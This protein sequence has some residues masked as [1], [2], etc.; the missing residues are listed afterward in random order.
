MG[1]LVSV[2][3]RYMPCL[4][5]AALALGMGQRV[6]PDAAWV[7]AND[8][9]L[10]YVGRVGFE[11][12][13]VAS[14]YYSASGFKARFRGRSLAL[15]FEEDDYGPA[16]S[17]GV[18]IDGAPEI[19]IRLVPKLDQ[20]YVVA[21]GLEDRVHDLEVFRRQDTYG[22]VAKFRGMLLD[23]GAKLENPPARS[24]RKIEF[25]GDS[26][27]G[28]T[29]TIAFGYE[30]KQDGAIA[31]ENSDAFL[32]DG[33]WSFGAI[34]ARRLHAE[35]NIEGIGGL[36]LLDH[37]GWFGGSLDRTIGL[38]TTWDK[39]DPIGGQFS[40]WNFSLFTPD[41]VVISI[42]QNDARGGNIQDAAWR[43]EWKDAYLHVLEGLRGHYPKAAIVLTTTILMHDLEWDRAIE[44]V[45][46]EWN[47]AHKRDSICYFAFKRTGK[48]TPGHPRLAEQEE[49][50]REL[51]DFLE[52]LRGAWR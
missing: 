14:F 4:C 51:A 50:G 5:F 49:M 27:M 9:K 7:P 43:R 35:A 40:P 36:S 33:Y 34:A 29:G 47:E 20:S 28:G 46:A 13:R 22:G 31:Y 11:D 18:K 12:P 19:P 17:F 41:V 16:N 1:D 21:V 24:R 44:E 25:F 38:A 30:G 42:G 48:A 23:K 39:L 8:P 45:V 37:T 6:D 2:T 15:R 3:I 52:H 26:V 10:Q 32:N